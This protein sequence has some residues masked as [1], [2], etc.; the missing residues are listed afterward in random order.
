[1][2]HKTDVALEETADQ[3][4][5]ELRL[6]CVN[7]KRLKKRFHK[8][9]KSW[10]RYARMQFTWQNMCYDADRLVNIRREIRE[11]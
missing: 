2:A 9:P 8:K 4:A 10:K 6:R 5:A 3:I 7:Y 1:M 11:G